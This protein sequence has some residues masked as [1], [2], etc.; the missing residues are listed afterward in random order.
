M[1]RNMLMI[2]VLQIVMVVGCGQSSSS[3]PTDLCNVQAWDQCANVARRE[4]G[5][6]ATA[7][8]RA[9]QS[10]RPFVLCDDAAF[11]ACM[12]VRK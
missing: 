4:C 8:E 6:S 5:L 10:C 3:D 1:R 7:S 12:D 9:L 2:M 11:D